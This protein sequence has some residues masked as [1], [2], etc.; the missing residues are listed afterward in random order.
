[1]EWKRVSGFED[2]YEV[3]SSGQVRSLTR[4]IYTSDGK[5]YEIP[6]KLLKISDNGS[7]YKFVSLQKHSKCTQRT[8]HRLVAE[9]FIPNPENKTTVNHKD[10]DKSNND[11]SN[12]EWATYSENNTHALATGLRR[13]WTDEARHRVSIASKLRESKPVRCITTGQVF[14]SMRDAEQTL[15]L[16][17]SVVSTSIYEMRET[18]GYR[19]EFVDPNDA[20]KPI[21]KKKDGRTLKR[22]IC[23]VN[24]GEVF[25]NMSIADRHYNLTSGDVSRSIK[26]NRTIKGF[27]FKYAD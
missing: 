9:A 24:T 11:V 15:G 25:D 23:C 3:S 13:G 1:M 21:K 5:S 27:K 12:L 10:G 14:S 19:F 26:F 6:G 17:A 7:G 16:G 22:P 4:T 20:Y 18:S 8:V 2:S